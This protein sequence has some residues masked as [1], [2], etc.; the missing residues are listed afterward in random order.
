MNNSVTVARSINH[1]IV[2]IHS[3]FFVPDQRQL[4]DKMCLPKFAN[5]GFSGLGH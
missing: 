2:L 5:S 1:D 4:E 3:R